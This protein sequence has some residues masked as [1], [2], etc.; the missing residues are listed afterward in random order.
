VAELLWNR[1]DW[2]AEATAWIR[3]RVEVTG[4]IEQPHVRWWSTVLRV[5]AADGDLFFKAVQ[6]VHRFEAALTA[7][8]A[9]LQP[10]RVTEVIDVDA[11]RGW[12]LMRDAGTRLRELVESSADL[13]HWERLLPEYAQL[14][15]EVA[16]YREELLALDV[17]DERLSVLPG[18]L[19]ELLATRPYGLSD[20]E[21]RRALDAVP[22]FEEMCLTLAED[23]LPETIQHD[24]L[25]DGQA[26]V[27]DGRYLVF[28]WG[29]S[30]VSHPFHS[31]TVT[32]RSIAWRLDLPPGGAELR[33]LRDIYLEPFGRAPELADL[34]YRTGTL[35]R[36]I[37]WHRMVSAREPEVVTEDDLAGP[38]YGIRRFLEGGP[39]GAWRE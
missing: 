34:A 39:I 20:D 18:L 6:P 36:A 11:E 27:R 5:P 10:G 9:E 29:D 2:L 8:L 37:A 26:F 19:R 21:H 23:G 17:P 35:A 32:L 25:H 22:R 31:L 16:P 33:R 3:E 30:C 14:Q 13:H 24:D 12:L 28:D 4:E 7:R 15:I 38:A 1:P